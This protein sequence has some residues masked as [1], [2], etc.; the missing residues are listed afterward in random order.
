MNRK[1]TYAVT[2]N[3]QRY[4]Y[5]AN[6]TYAQ[7]AQDVQDQYPYDILLVNRDGKLR[8]LYRHLD[9][10]CNLTMITAKDKPGRQSY[11]RSALFLLLKA[12]YDTAG[13]ENVER[14]VVEFS[15]SSALFLHAT[16]NFNLDAELLKRVEAR[17]RELAAANLPIE[18]KTLPTDDAIELFRRQRFEDKA[19]LFRY[20]I[21]SHVNVYCLDGFYDYFY[22]YMLPSTGYL[23]VFALEPYEDGFLLR[24]P[25]KEDPAK[26]GEF[27][28][29]L[30][31]FRTLYDD[32][33]HAA[34]L[35]ISNVGELN[36]LIARGESEGLILTHEAL[37]E[38]RIGDIAQDIAGRPDVR[39]VM[40]A[41]PSSSGK[42]TFSHRLCTQLRACGMRPHPIATDNYFVN[43]D[44]TPRDADGNFDFEGLG[45]MDVEQLNKDMSRLLAGETVEIPTYN[46]KK[47][48]REYNG[49]YL[50]LGPQDIL[51]IEGIHCLNDALSYSLPHESKFKIYISCLTVLNVDD[52][53]RIPTTDARLLRRIE[54][55][56][57]TRGHNAQATIRM[58]PSVRRGEENN[59]FPYQDSAD[60][61]FNSALIFETAVLQAYLEPLL[62][63]IPRD[64][65]EYVEA[66]RLLKFLNY[67]LPL[68]D[69]MAPNT[70]IIR[71]FIGGGC[72]KV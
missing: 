57:R 20:R 59:I 19:R 16:G 65:E 66:K 61:V 1:A 4:E 6:T 49:D 26:L 22:G 29:P 28:P 38:K 5:P 71:E 51:V 62:F 46:F 54:R 24:M 30:K 11:E 64:S 27:N 53:N 41:G 15:L 25:S 45:A 2:I 60:V 52:H 69:D 42:T 37:M 13:A 50:T 23:K 32:T 36:D 67:F 68:P 35:G 18:K 7:I 8:E 34:A 3:G 43:R 44:E 21:D 14:V 39:F 63:A 33:C 58:W 70:S 17:M 72:Y 40:I 55:D 10:D 56:A 12:F 31:V 47:G 9:R 48:C